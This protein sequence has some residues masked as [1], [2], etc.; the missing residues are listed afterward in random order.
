MS[1]QNLTTEPP[2]FT[3]VDFMSPEYANDRHKYIAE[4]LRD[5]PVFYYPPMNLWVISKY[6][7]VKAAFKDYE[8]F[9]S[10]AWGMLPCPDDLKARAADMDTDVRINTMDPPEHA[11]LRIPV[12]QAFLPGNLTSVEENG[13]RIANRLI[14]KFID[15]GEC[16]L[17]HDYCYWFPLYVALDLLG[18]PEDHAEDYHRWAMS[19]F[20]LFTPKRPDGTTDP[21]HLMAM[22]PEVLRANWENLA[23]S[24]DYLRGIV[25]GLDENPQTNLLSKLLELRESDGSRTLSVSSIVRNAL[26][27]VSAGHDTTATLIAHLTFFSLSVPG[28]K[29]TLKK[30]PEAIHHAILETLRMQGSADGLFRRTM[31]EVEIGGVKLPKGA[32]VYLYT[33]AANLDPDVFPNPSDFEMDRPN[34]KDLISFGFGRHV[35]VGQSLARMEAEIAYGELLRRIPSLR[36]K[37]GFEKL[38]YNPSVMN[39][40]AQSLPVVWDV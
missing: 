6:D 11:K 14:D 30:D 17:L 15:K 31:R 24:N 8:T 10:A 35:C 3:A 32:I 27:F 18:L 37:P 19:F 12:Q 33:T 5:S 7:D 29:E 2:T 25:E 38:A 20:A 9:S 39:V 23:E 16:D 26:D 40:Q 34:A 13:R 4:M 1:Q 36:L 28:L 22:P 21:A